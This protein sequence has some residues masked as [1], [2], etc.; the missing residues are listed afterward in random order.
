MSISSTPSVK[1][2]DGLNMFEVCL[3]DNTYRIWIEFSLNFLLLNSLVEQIPGLQPLPEVGH[4]CVEYSR[5]LSLAYY[6][7]R[8]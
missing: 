4:F 3:I 8:S 7:Y 1:P 2:D 5:Q 6:R